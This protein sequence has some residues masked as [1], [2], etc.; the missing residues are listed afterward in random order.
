LHLVQVSHARNAQVQPGNQC[1][2]LYLRGL[3]TRK[4][5]DVSEML[6]YQELKPLLPMH[7]TYSGVQMTPI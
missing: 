7:R 1:K 5:A 2:T 3:T 6:T 4:E